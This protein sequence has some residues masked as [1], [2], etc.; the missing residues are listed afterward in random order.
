[1]IVVLD[2]KCL[3]SWARTDDPDNL[4]R[5]RLDHL[6]ANISAAKGRVVL[7]APVVAEFLVHSDLGTSDWLVALERKS[8]IV[9]AP[10][11]RRAALE[12]ALIDRAALASGNKRG[13]RK[14]AWQRIKIDRQIVAI[15]R[16]AG[17]VSIVTDDAG[18]TT[19]ARS[20]GL[21][22]QSLSELDL[23]DSARQSKLDLQPMS[24]A[25]RA[26]DQAVAPVGP[27]AQRQIPATNGGGLSSSAEAHLAPA[28]R[29][30]ES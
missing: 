15:A 20:V 19:T 29:A 1:M 14:E 25:V 8:S 3:I 7:P 10:F 16:V 2:T 22:V 28:P 9:V 6:F 23:P 24:D 27:D 13:G 17:A 18:L 5:D 30:S 21:Q 12:C 4:D 11:D 26:A